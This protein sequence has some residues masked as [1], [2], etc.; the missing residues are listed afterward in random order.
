VYRRAIQHL[1]RRCGSV[2]AAG[3]SAHEPPGLLESG[4]AG[5][6]A[7]PEYRM[8]PSRVWDARLGLSG[9]P[10]VVVLTPASPR[11]LS[12]SGGINLWSTPSATQSVSTTR[13]ARARPTGR[14]SCPKWWTRPDR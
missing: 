7:A 3:L 6:D 4:D 2:G 9:G 8:P 12:S 13:A 14:T 5:E 10:V 11:P 1:P